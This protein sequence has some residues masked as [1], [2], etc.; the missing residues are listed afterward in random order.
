MNSVCNW[1]LGKRIGSMK[2]IHNVK[3]PISNSAMSS[4]K[5]AS[6][7][8]TTAT[9]IPRTGTV[10]ISKVAYDLCARANKG[11]EICYPDEYK[12]IAK[13]DPRIKEYDNENKNDKKTTTLSAIYPEFCKV[14]D[15]AERPCIHVT[16]QT[17]P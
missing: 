5:S 12:N 4:G 15:G 10:A 6:Y 14:N 2:V 17:P 8:E 7:L 13:V 9:T 16:V 1:V 11:K 3:T